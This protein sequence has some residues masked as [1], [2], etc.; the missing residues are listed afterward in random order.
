MNLVN[1]FGIVVGTKCILIS[2]HTLGW[3]AKD[4]NKLKMD[5]LHYN[6]IFYDYSIEKRTEVSKKKRER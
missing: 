4:C 5:W 6:L 1:G 3:L 2:M